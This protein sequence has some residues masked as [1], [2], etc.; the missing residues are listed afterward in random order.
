MF[1]LNKSIMHKYILLLL[2]VLVFGSLSAQETLVESDSL[3][4]TEMLISPGEIST[5]IT[6][7]SNRL[8]EI[9]D[10][11]EPDN[12]ILNV[13]LIVREYTFSLQADKEEIMDA[14]HTMSYQR[15]ENLLRAWNNYGSKFRALVSTVKNRVS[16]LETV[17]SE[18]NLELE[19][20][21]NIRELL[22]KENYPEEIQQSTDTVI[23]SLSSQL[24]A[25]NTRSDSL[26]IIQKRQSQM[27]IFIDDMIRLLETEQKI[28]QSNYFIVDSK[29]IWSGNDSTTNIVHLRADLK[30]NL[31]ENYDILKIYLRSN[32]SIVI[33]QLLFIVGLMIGFVLLGRMWPT[34]ELDANSRRE[35]QAGVIIRHP[36]ISSLIISIIISIFFYS[37]RPL[38]LGNFLLLLMIISSAV[39]LP[40]LIT[41]KIRFPVILL[42]VLFIV[43]SIQDYLPGNSLP[44][45]III[46]FLS[47][48]VLYLVYFIFKIKNE[49][50]L[51]Q[52]GDRILKLFMSIFALLMIITFIADIIGSVKLSNFLLNSTIRTLTF[53]SV[54]V[55]GVI[56][57][58]SMMILFIKGKHTQ[59][60]PM[61]EKLKSLIDKYVRPSINWV[62][63]ILWFI[64]TLIFFRLYR[65]FQNW[66]GNLMDT[67][68]MIST[69]PISVGA[70]IRFI[71]IV[72]FTYIIIRFVKNIFKDEW[73]V[74]SRLPRGTAEALSMLIRYI[75]VA[76]GI[77]LALDAIGIK[78][79]KFGFMAGALG[80]G[81]GFGLQNVVLNFIAGLILSF[82]QP[83]HVGDVIEVDQDMGRV[84]EIGVRA[85]KI[86]TWNGSE[87]IIP[88]GIL[89][90]KRVINWTLTDEKRRLVIP[91]RTAFDATPKN[92]IEILKTVAAKHPNTL[93]FPAPMAMFNGYG[94]SSLDFT[95]YCWVEF[96]V[97]LITKSDIAVSA[98]EALAEAGIPVPLP[99]QKIQID[100]KGD[101]HPAE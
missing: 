89:I 82:E 92:V 81:I 24:T 72:F 3:E 96:N 94:S 79:D 77:Y 95:L 21:Q 69:V 90:S 10:I 93:D 100:K 25:A 68:F 76:F 27:I 37:N 1:E 47:A 36:F 86:M 84:M 58:N 88:N 2:F 8:I 55:T 52:I 61:F 54:I 35:T 87:V 78:M 11:V 41:K 34:E 60:I 12:Y 48:A 74:N 18:L 75:F 4:T 26:Y 9:S 32:S 53:S 23:K 29:P 20:W 43:N 71:L 14:L 45:R 80:V 6:K 59:S 17:Q 62:A 65:P 83:I 50:G 70:I 13:D 98:H 66:I 85:S 73:V 46:L 49:F 101:E 19:Q 7:L 31:N 91:I 16:E 67:E 51:R 63:L 40:M 44:N 64:G 22:I 57:I 99:V 42:L 38:M 15:L 33:L 5:N 28:F 39:L 30:S 56:I 97:G